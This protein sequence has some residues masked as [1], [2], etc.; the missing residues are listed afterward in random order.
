MT[1]F[2]DSALDD[3][4]ALE[5]ADE[6]FRPLAEAGARLR[7]EA[8]RALEQ[9][10]GVSSDEDR[11][12]AVVA[13]GPEAR[14]LRAVLELSCPVPFVAWSHQGLPA[15]VGPLDV[16]VVLGGPG[17]LGSARE[18]L[19]R[20]SRLIVVARADS[21]LAVQTVS[22]STTLLPVDTDDPLAGAVVALMALRRFGLAP[23]TDHDAMADAMDAVARECSHARDL[24]SNPAKTLAIELAGSE[25][26]VWGGTVLASRASRRIV[27][28]VRAA[29]GRVALAADASDLAPILLA[30]EPPDPFEDPF[31]SGCERRRLSL[32]VVSDGM[33]DEATRQARTTLETNAAYAGVRVSSLEHGTGAALERYVT[34][35]QRGRFAAAYLRLGLM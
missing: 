23:Q 19:R 32:V 8:D 34:V 14:L 3:A 9:L 10:A 2:N 35:L 27:E 26:L 31:E 20:G 30:A 1:E 33:E 22:R 17:A 13:I 18:A 6:L 12:R 21:N 11:P 24:S 25:P 4:E 15:W 29:S 28:A 16:V 7:R 5:A